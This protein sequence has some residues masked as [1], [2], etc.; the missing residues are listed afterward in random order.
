MSESG[1]V[2]N[3]VLTGVVSRRGRR[4]HASRQPDMSAELARCML[5]L[6]EE[7]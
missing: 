2:W 4:M 5:S 3:D 7:S 6:L 1:P